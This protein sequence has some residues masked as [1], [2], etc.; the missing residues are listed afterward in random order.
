M[1]CWRAFHGLAP[2]R[3]ANNTATPELPLLLIC[4]STS[5]ITNK[6]MLRAVAMALF[7]RFLRRHAAM[8]IFSRYAMAM[9][10]AAM[11][12]FTLFR[13]S[14]IIQCVTPVIS[15]KRRKVSHAPPRHADAPADI[16]CCWRQIRC[17]PRH[18]IPNGVTLRRPRHNGQRHALFSLPMMMPAAAMP[19]MLI[20]Q[21]AAAAIHAITLMFTIT[22]FA[23]D[24]TLSP[25]C[26][27]AASASSYRY[28]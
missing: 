22:L 8:L 15:L 6:Q 5:E 28:Y 12:C 19:V 3:L 18:I 11:I 1:L 14:A 23:A 21:R 20:R 25:R 17:S 7:R 10:A 27:H 16:R 13:Q 4:L 2:C 24:D 9:P 26:R